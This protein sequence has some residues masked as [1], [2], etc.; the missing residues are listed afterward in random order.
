MKH[1]QISLIQM[2]IHLGQPQENFERAAAFT[3]EAAHLGSDLVLLPELWVTG[4]ALER[5]TELA[6]PIGEGTFQRMATLARKHGIALG[7]SSLELDG[8]KVYN[9]FVLYHSDGCLMAAYRKVHLFRLMDEH[10]WL[11]PGG[12][13][14]NAGFPWGLTGLAICYDLRFPEMFR[15]YAAEGALLVLVPAEWPAS[16]QAAWRT[17]LRARAIENQFFVV[18]VNRVGESKGEIYGGASAVIDPQGRTII[19]GGDQEALLTAELD[20]D[21][22]ERTRKLIPILQD[23]RLD[24]YG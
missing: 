6:S 20:L 17:L 11:S 23:R 1:L 4:Y 7:G 9:T 24:L 21:E 3:S 5:V 8:G 22:V 13:L 12:S 18:G 2:D 19:E 10:L 14:V 16:R 15:R